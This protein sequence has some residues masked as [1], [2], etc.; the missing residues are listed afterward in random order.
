MKRAA[1]SA[2]LQIASRGPLSRQGAEG[3]PMRTGNGQGHTQVSGRARGLRRWLR[4]SVRGAG[5][6]LVLLCLSAA[7]GHAAGVITWDNGGAGNAWSTA[8]NWNPDAVPG[9]G[10]NVVIGSGSEVD[11]S[12]TVEVNGLDLAGMLLGSGQLTVTGS[13]TWTG[14]ELRG[15][16]S[17][18]IAPGATLSIDGA[19]ALTLVERTLTNQGTVTFAGTEWVRLYDGAT[20]SNE[21]DALFEAQSDAD[22]DHYSGDVSTFANAGTYRKSGGMGTS[23]VAMAFN[24]TGT[25]DVQ[26]GTVQLTMGARAA[27][28]RR[29]CRRVRCWNSE[30][31]RTPCRRA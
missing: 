22:L 24:N 14:G 5:F 28:R 2:R 16:G 17:T 21:V 11:L 9:A 27:V 6:G 18:V 23:L 3:A 25:M 13:M 15:S 26:T 7:S 10:D 12:G 20:I 8:A 31:G 1:C 30:E 19:A 4:T 29:R